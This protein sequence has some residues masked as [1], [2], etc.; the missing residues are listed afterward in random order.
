MAAI[1]ITGGPACG[2]STASEALSLQLGAERF[3]ADQ[4][5]GHCL[6]HDPEVQ[7]A[8]A[9]WLQL[10][11]YT[12]S[13]EERA[14]LRK[15]SFADSDFRTQLENLIHPRIR[16]IWLPRAEACAGNVRQHFVAEIPLLYE[17]KLSQLFDRVVV[18]GVAACIQHQRLLARGLDEETLSRLLAAQWPLAEKVRL[19]DHVIWN[20]GERDLLISQIDRLSAHCS[21]ET[22]YVRT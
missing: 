13:L 4:A 1:A 7:S 22:R 19:A 10:P 17:K 12:D 20:D 3:D 15:R 16:K 6:A 21:V 11:L 8:L 5:V 14:L 9:T 18:I 2:K